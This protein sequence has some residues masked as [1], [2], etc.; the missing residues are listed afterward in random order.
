MVEPWRLGSIR[1]IRVTA[2]LHECVIA[3]NLFAWVQ[4]YTL[5]AGRQWD[6]LTSCICM[7][8]VRTWDKIRLKCSY[9]LIRRTIQ[10]NHACMVFVFFCNIL[11]LVIF[12]C[13][14]YLILTFSAQLSTGYP[15]HSKEQISHAIQRTAKSEKKAI[16]RT[17]VL[18]SQQWFRPWN[19]HL[20]VSKCIRVADLA[21]IIHRPST[22]G[23]TQ[24]SL[25]PYWTS[26]KKT[27]Q[28]QA[29]GLY[30]FISHF[31]YSFIYF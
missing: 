7:H 13:F 26:L 31:I 14:L 20:A 23:K 29:Y 27:R 5:A 24:A 10:M 30:Q 6:T 11:I 16:V 21:D 9:A 1:G 17:E 25:W 8:K 4:P 22:G 28:V 2:K 19:Y 18:V 3:S 15:Y 12:S